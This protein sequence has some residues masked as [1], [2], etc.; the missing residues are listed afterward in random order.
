MSI[1]LT[2]ITN[3]NE[4]YTNHYFSTVFEENTS[5]TISGWNAAARE[6]EEIR[7]PWS[8]L[9]QNARHRDKFIVIVAGYSEPMETFLESNPGL[10]SRFNKSILFD[11]YTELELYEILLSFCGN[12]DMRLNDEGPV[13][14]EFV[15]SFNGFVLFSTFL[16]DR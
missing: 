12:Y 2:G 5:A 13:E 10:K 16:N 14:Q 4:Y 1:D 15:N 6:S 8:L 9:R 7:T 3:K 11:D